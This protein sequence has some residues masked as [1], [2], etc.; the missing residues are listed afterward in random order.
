[1]YTSS[2]DKIST[3]QGRPQV[4]VVGGVGME[5]GGLNNDVTRPAF[6]LMNEEYQGSIELRRQWIMRTGKES[7]AAPQMYLVSRSSLA[8]ISPRPEQSAPLQT[9]VITHE[10]RAPF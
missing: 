9:N 2:E 1:M 10:I 4:G 3:R 6:S 8:S 5:P 7:F